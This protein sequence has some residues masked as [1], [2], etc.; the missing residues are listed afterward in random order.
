MLQLLTKVE[1]ARLL[2]ISLPTLD[3]LTKEG[4]LKRVVLGKRV[5]FAEDDIEAAIA[6]SK[7]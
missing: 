6:A 5:L 7:N 1:A 4:A 2:R 3:R